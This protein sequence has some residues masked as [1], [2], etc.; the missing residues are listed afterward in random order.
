MTPEEIARV[1]AAMQKVEPLDIPQDV[2]DDLDAWERKVV[3]YG[4]DKMDKDEEK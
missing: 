4:I 1:L 3:Q 2:A